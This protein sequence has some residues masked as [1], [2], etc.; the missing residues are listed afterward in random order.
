MTKTNL[1]DLI[2]STDFFA[3]E[4]ILKNSMAISESELK[5][6]I[7]RELKNMEI[8]DIDSFI[9][10]LL[11]LYKNEILRQDKN[12]YRSIIQEVKKEDIN[13]ITEHKHPRGRFITVLNDNTAMYVSTI[14]DLSVEYYT[15]K[16]EMLADIILK[17][18]FSIKYNAKENQVT[19]NSTVSSADYVFSKE[20]L[21]YIKNNMNDITK[22]IL[23]R[24]ALLTY[25]NQ[26]NYDLF[27]DY[28]KTTV[29]NIFDTSINTPPKNINIGDTIQTKYSDNATVIDIDTES[30]TLK[31]DKEIQN[32]ITVFT[33]V[34]SYKNEDIITKVISPQEDMEMEE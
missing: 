14:S 18:C 28:L 8:D 32:E 33:D 24:N 34:I 5:S 22:E 21:L 1:Q 17:Q 20:I 6:I 26:N 15:S 29:L 19:I 13:Y 30:Q 16:N 3:K 12:A 31:L 10:S 2:A 7:S 9:S 27:K 25:K 23:N 11:D 4:C